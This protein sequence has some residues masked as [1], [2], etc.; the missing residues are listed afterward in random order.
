MNLRRV[1][2]VLSFPSWRTFRSGF[3]CLKQ[4]RAISVHFLVVECGLAFLFS[5][6]TA[7]SFW[8]QK[9]KDWIEFEDLRKRGSVGWKSCSHFI[10]LIIR[11]VIK[12]RMSLNGISLEWERSMLLLSRRKN[13][14]SSNFQLTNDESQDGTEARSVPKNTRQMRCDFVSSL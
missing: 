3:L 4:K 12:T 5:P 13:A 8:N 14:A 1:T 10:S 7:V 11:S 6:A 9:C 2:K